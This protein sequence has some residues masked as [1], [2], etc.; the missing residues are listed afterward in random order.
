[1]ILY[2][3]VEINDN[4]PSTIC[5]NCKIELNRAYEFKQQCIKSYET[6]QIDGI[7]SELADIRFS[8]IDY[9]KSDDDI[10]DCDNPSDCDNHS[11][12]D[13]N[14]DIIDVVQEKETETKKVVRTFRKR[15]KSKIDLPIKCDICCEGFSLQD[16]LQIHM[17]SHPDDDN[18]VC[19]MCNKEFNSLKVLRRHVKIH[20]KKKPFQV[21]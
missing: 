13:N 16:D 10:Q 20:M 7:H 17:I 9:I 4:L 19:T 12:N 18:P 8:L 14:D 6:L 21:K 1:M 15:K 2:F 3:Q 11:N 5:N